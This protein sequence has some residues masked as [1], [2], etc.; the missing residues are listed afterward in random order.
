MDLRYIML[1]D[2]FEDAVL[3]AAKLA[4]PGEAVLFVSG[5]CKLGYV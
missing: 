1:L 5:M 4:E 3:T 2:T